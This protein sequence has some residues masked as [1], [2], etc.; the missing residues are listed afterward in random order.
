[1]ALAY[2]PAYAIDDDE[3]APVA[4]A[5][6]PV[7]EPAAEPTTEPVPERE[8]VL[9]EPG[10]DKLEPVTP[11]PAT[12]PTG[13]MVYDPSLTF[14][15]AHLPDPPPEAE[16][17]DEGGGGFWAQLA[18]ASTQAVASTGVTAQMFND[19]AGGDQNNAAG[20]IGKW[21]EE[22]ATLGPGYQP[23]IED[24]T[25]IG[26]FSDASLYVRESL[27]AGVGSMVAPFLAF[28]TGSAAGTPVLGVTAALA[29]TFS[30]N[31]AESYKALHADPEIQKALAEGKI[32]RQQIA[33]VATGTGG[34][35]ASLDA[36][37]LNKLA[38]ITGI[39]GELLGKAA[40]EVARKTLVRRVLEGGATEGAT[41]MAQNIV[42]E[43]TRMASGG[44][45]DLDEAAIRSINALFTGAIPGAAISAK[46]KSSGKP[47]GQTGN[48][49]DGTVTDDQTKPETAPGAGG[50]GTAQGAPPA[51]PAGGGDTGGE[52]ETKP[53]VKQHIGTSTPMQERVT[54]LR[55]QNPGWTLGRAFAEAQRERTEAERPPVAPGVDPDLGAAAEATT[56]AAPNE[57]ASRAEAPGQPIAGMTAE[58]T[59]ADEL[60]M[61][62]E[63]Y[64][65]TIAR[66]GAAPAAEPVIPSRPHRA[67]PRRPRRVRHRVCRTRQRSRYR[68]SLPRFAASSPPQVRQLSRQGSTRQPR[69]RLPKFRHRRLLHLSHHRLH[70]LQLPRPR[71]HL[72]R[73]RSRPRLL[74]PSQSSRVHLLSSSRVRSCRRPRRRHNSRRGTISS[75]SN[76][77]PKPR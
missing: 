5:P 13:P 2:D 43:A 24:F 57:F 74:S 27:G 55:K 54:E 35:M 14:D 51:Q 56:G 36:V 11:K 25:K 76:A 30:Q 49:G 77:K 69:L 72:R 1:M 64:R 40:K 12:R 73:A 29:T 50:P 63:Q 61:S 20:Q 18:N 10:A 60:G 42:Q 67:G 32:S 68:R 62:V 3:E 48:E 71:R 44:E 52:D 7:A 4:P 66:A 21:I 8:P 65:E 58:Q 17:K 26:S 15:P 16:A 28:I 70:L 53:E 46:G 22:A 33:A 45:K 75:R 31:A 6:A 47:A 39:G 9:E 59:E 23:K 34:V 41:E 38:K 19:L 37:G